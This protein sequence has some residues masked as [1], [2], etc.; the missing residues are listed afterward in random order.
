[1]R[2][3]T[4]LLLVMAAILV[5]ITYGVAFSQETMAQE[6][7]APVLTQ[8]VWGEVV[9]VDSTSGMIVVKYLDYESEQEQEMAIMVTDTTKFEEISSINDINAGDAISIDFMVNSEGNNIAENITTENRA[10]MMEEMPP[11]Q[12]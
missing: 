1:M 11:M 7:T 3:R 2:K 12:Q 10:E 9:S 5:F 8:W 6:E 4:D